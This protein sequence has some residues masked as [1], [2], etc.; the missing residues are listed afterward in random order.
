MAM[1][2]KASG[3]DRKRLIEAANALEKALTE[4]M[5]AARLAIAGDKNALIKF[6]KLVT[7]IDPLAEAVI[8]VLGARDGL[9]AIASEMRAATSKLVVDKT[10]EGKIF[11]AMKDIAALMAKLADASKRG[12]KREIIELSRQI[13]QITVSTLTQAMESAG[14]CTDQQLSDNMLTNAQAAKN[15]ATQL[16]ILCAVKAS[17]SDDD[18]TVKA[19]LVKC[20]KNISQALT[21]LCKTAETV[22]ATRRR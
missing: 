2:A 22:K 17:T 20:A 18:P 8:N 4:V 9:E 10:S 7:G 15:F 5:D 21:T 12:A 16:K 1:A 19:Q 3:K 13:C 11:A 6:L 14:T